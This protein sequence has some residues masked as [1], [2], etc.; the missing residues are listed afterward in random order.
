MIVESGRN[1]LEQQNFVW[2][3]LRRGRVFPQNTKLVKLAFFIA[4]IFKQI[5]YTHQSQI[6]IRYTMT[7][8]I[9]NE[10]F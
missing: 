6:F 4:K 3:I 9:L 1:V 8:L 5:R 10:D 7:S 2:L